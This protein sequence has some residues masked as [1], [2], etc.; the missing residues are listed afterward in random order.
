[1]QGMFILK[2]TNQ[3]A[4]G[5]IDKPFLKHLWYSDLI[6]WW[7]HWVKISCRYHKVILLLKRTIWENIY[8]LIWNETWNNYCKDYFSNLLQNKLIKEAITNEK[9]IYCHKRIQN[10]QDR[11]LVSNELMQFTIDSIV[12]ITLTYYTE[13]LRKNFA[14]FRNQQYIIP[15]LC[16]CCCE[17]NKFS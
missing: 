4:R 13:A 9:C 6:I 1:M 8:S 3:I 16:A 15:L 5:L 10:F 11:C 17:P 14:F 2:R 12:S 7:Y